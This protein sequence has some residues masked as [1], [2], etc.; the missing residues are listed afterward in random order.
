MFLFAATILLSAFLLFLVQPIIAKQ[1]LPWFGGS[2]AV[3]T[4][5]MVFFQA[6]LLGGYA[7]AH[8]LTRHA[9]QRSQGTIHIVLLL[10][11][12]AVLPIIPAEAWKPGEGAD[13]LLRILGLLAVTIG[14]PYFLLSS[15]G[16]LIQKWFSSA[17]PSRTVYRLFALSNF[18]SLIG[19]LAYP[20]V[21]EPFATAQVQSWGWSAAYTLFVLTCA[22]C[23]WRARSLEPAQDG[24]RFIEPK[25]A[26]AFNAASNTASQDAD[27]TAMLAQ[28]PGAG[29]ILFWLICAA[30]GS[31]MLLAVTSHITQNVASIPF[32]WVLPL[33]LYL[34]SFVVCFE[35]RGGRGWYVRAYWIVPVLAFAVAMMWGLSAEQGV[36][37]I[38]YAIPLYSAGLF[39][40]SVFFHGELAATK[41]APA[42]LTQ[43]YLALSAGGA[44]GGLLVAVVAPHV[45]N[46]WY[47]L[48]V[49]L[50]A[51]TLL[52]LWVLRDRRIL[53]AASL[54]GL[55][56]TGWFGW[57]YMQFVSA[58]TLMMSRNFHGTL[59]IKQTEAGEYQV[60]RLLHGV[61]LHG[62]Q[63][64]SPDKRKTPGTYYSATSGIGLAL[65][66]LRAPGTGMRVGVIGLGTGTL[67]AYGKAGDVYRI[68]ELDP[69]V[70]QVARTWFHYLSDTA[71]RSEI[72]LGDARLSMERELAQGRPQAYDVIAIDAFS[73]DSIPVHLITR[74]ALAVYARHL[75][76]DGVIAFHVSNRFLDLPPVV[77]SLADD[78]GFRAA[79]IS[80]QPANIL[81]ASGSDWVLLTRN[82]DFLELPALARSEDIPAQA[83]LRIWTDQFNNLFQILK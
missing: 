83:G 45:F 58:D 74:E 22:T 41:P 35:G 59:R 55:G 78:A 25:A 34:L 76:S 29:R 66:H 7:Y 18:G 60:R 2:A 15:T 37:H 50:F 51:L 33:T 68:Y 39:A 61:I 4:V 21:V 16:P 81:G 79:R 62:E 64:T 6:L 24:A 38:Q 53:L 19:L 5:C 28:A 13:P 40:C 77:R 1:I 12:L 26:A 20:F 47:E 82:R 10:L 73:S 43:F 48:P 8:W 42:W 44:L 3:W 67:A 75:K 31:I 30:L 9:A 56:A 23:A 17:Y 49:A 57:Q 65:Q 72:V 54:V 14:L 27:M 71:A 36:L 70:A 46:T 63:F 52:A 80:D 11:S 69:E 32:L